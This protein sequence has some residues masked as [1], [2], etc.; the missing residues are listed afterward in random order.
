LVQQEG[1]EVWVQSSPDR[2]FPDADYA[3]AGARVV[4]DLSACP[5]IM[6]IKE[7]PPEKIEAGKTYIYFSHTIKGQA[8]NLPALRRLLQQKC[9]LIDYERIVDEQGR[10]LVFFGNYAGMAGMLDT[11][12]ALG[13][14]LQHEGVA[15]P[16]TQVRQAHRYHDVERAKGEMAQVA[17][18]IR[19]HGLPPMLRP[20]ICGFAGYGQVS[21]GAQQIYDSLPIKPIEPDQVASAPPDADVCYKVVFRE[22]HMVKRIDP[23]AP[24]ALQEYYQH[25]DRYRS[26]FFEYVPHLTVLVNCIY[27]EAKYP[28]LLTLDQLRKLY[29]GPAPA[30]LRAIGDVSCD[31][32]GSIECTVKTTTPDNPVF[33]Y[34]PATGAVHDGVAGNGPVILAV[35]FLPCELPVDA[36]RFFSRSLNPF[37]VPLARADYSRSLSASG[38]PL[39]IQRA[40]IV[41]HGELTPPYKY[42][43]QFLK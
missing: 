35:D 30:R 32:N 9:Q 17:D 8:G 13:Q 21:Q 38:L 14:R 2:A 16:F 41:Y 28:R 18:A 40:T 42:L 25:P 26:R 15:N 29:G 7:I 10:R 5:I 22:Q 11:L 36:S 34:E 39:E 6:G 1:L 43:E 4:D 23:S 27:W 24:F 3:A 31:L 20:F 33:V 12:W 19:R 37:I